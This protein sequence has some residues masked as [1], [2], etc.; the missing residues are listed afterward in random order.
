MAVAN[1]HLRKPFP[2]PEAPAP[3][4]PAGE[5]PDTL[6]AQTVG[7]GQPALVGVSTEARDDGAIVVGAVP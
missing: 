5:R 1:R 4:V 3:Q 7:P 6:W 2:S